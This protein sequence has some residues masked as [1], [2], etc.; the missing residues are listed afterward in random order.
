MRL[1]PWPEIFWQEPCG[2]GRAGNLPSHPPRERHALKHV[3]FPPVINCSPLF[4]GYSTSN[5]HLFIFSISNDNILLVE[6]SVSRVWR[7]L[8]RTIESLHFIAQ[9]GSKW[10][11]WSGLWGQDENGALQNPEQQP[12]NSGI[13]LF[14]H[15]ARSPSTYH[16]ANQHAPV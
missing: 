15:A 6:S 7:D 5:R 10:A 11:T 9:T 13:T 2:G 16:V 3:N 4:Y 14:L 8:G 12:F 1:V